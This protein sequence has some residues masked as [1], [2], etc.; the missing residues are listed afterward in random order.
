MEQFMQVVKTI[1]KIGLMAGVE[2]SQQITKRKIKK[3]K[4]QS[5][6]ELSREQLQE[7]LKEKLQPKFQK[8]KKKQ[9]I[10]KPQ[11]I[12]MIIIIFTILV[13]GF[14]YHSY[15]PIISIFQ[16]AQQKHPEIVK[17]HYP[18]N[19]LSDYKAPRCG[20]QECQYFYAE[21]AF[22]NESTLPTILYVGGFHGDERL[23]PNIVTELL[24][25]LIESPLP[26]IKDR[27]FLLYPMV[28][29]YGYFENQREELNVDPNRDFDYDNT[30][31]KCLKTVA[32]RA[33][34][35]L[36]AKYTIQGAITFHGGDNSLTYPWGSANHIIDNKASEAPDDTVMREIGQLMDQYA[37]SNHL[38]KVDRYQFGRMTDVVYYVNGG[39]E[40]W[41][42]GFD[43]DGPKGQ[44][45]KINYDEL[46]KPKPR[47][48]TYLVEAGTDKFPASEY[49]GT[50]ESLIK[51]LNTWPPGEHDSEF[52]NINRNIILSLVFADM[53]HPYL[54]LRSINDTLTIRIGGCILVDELDIYQNDQ[55]IQKFKQVDGIWKNGKIFI[56]NIKGLIQ[57]RYSCDKHFFKQNNPDP[58]LPPQSYFM[59]SKNGSSLVRQ[60]KLIISEV[61]VSSLCG[62][63]YI[64]RVDQEYENIILQSLI[65]RPQPQIQNI[66]Y[67]GQYLWIIV[68]ASTFII[69]LFL[70]I[71]LFIRFRKQQNIK[72]R[73]QFELTNIQES[74]SV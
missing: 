33:L 47:A 40:D 11:I 37:S 29:S 51:Q 16:E 25:L 10:K 19:E 34:E 52:G 69:L 23:G 53:L 7:K 32:A 73:L 54:Y 22:K 50:Q 30:P 49:L 5:S 41:S 61:N 39:Y 13:N 72:N 38:L 60:T 67:K 8:K 3:I 1:R 57:I 31:D 4:K 20:K 43:W 42:Y 58:Q 9:G 12:E 65:E 14:E 15:D 26:F 21:V 27:R 56:E 36:Y 48:I 62:E 2:I 59:Q 68:I 64:D 18:L 55:I 24:L 74:G 66:N 45:N 71:V 63:T 28:N 17:L 35:T 46:S 44:C 6:D 70:L